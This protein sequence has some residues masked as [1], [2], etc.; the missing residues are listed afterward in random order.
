[1]RR[2]IIRQSIHFI[3]GCL[4]I[5]L[6]IGI[7][8]ENFL[9]INIG[10]LAFGYAIST[11]I[12]NGVKLPLF[13]YVVS[14]AERDLEKQLPGKGA[15]L[16]FTGTLITSILFYQNFIVLLGAIIVLVFGDSIATLIG[17]GFG[18]YRLWSKRTLEGSIAGIIVSF[19]VLSIIFPHGAALGA[20]IVG[21]A[22]EYLPIDDNLTI[23]IAAGIALTLLL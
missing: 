6:L 10:I 13:S 17:K 20:A 7:G 11:L 21:M 23:P 18:K 2:E 1:M 15:L 3:F 19:L 9:I 14:N 16:F 5:L 22:M 4:V 8:A 12:K